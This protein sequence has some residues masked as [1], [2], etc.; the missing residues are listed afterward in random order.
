MTG[1]FKVA[2]K[3]CDECLF[4][5]AKIVSDARR[6]DILAGCKEDDSFFVCHKYT[7]ENLEGKLSDDEANVCCKGFW[8]HDPDACTAM[9]LA[10]RLG[11]VELVDLPDS[12]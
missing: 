9:Q 6:D 5:D 11:F 8:D 3:C 10:H 2:R 12:E 7:V 4:S 1:L